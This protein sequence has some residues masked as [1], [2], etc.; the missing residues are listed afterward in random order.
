M[1]MTLHGCGWKPWETS[2]A[3]LDTVDALDKDTDVSRCDINDVIALT[4][5][6]YNVKSVVGRMIDQE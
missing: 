3:Y 1:M 5:Y 6:K 4:L 2:C